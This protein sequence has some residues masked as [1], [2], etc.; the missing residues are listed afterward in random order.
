LIPFKLKKKKR[1]IN[2]RG[3]K[4]K[5]RGWLPVGKRGVRS[6]RKETG[7]EE[8]RVIVTRQYWRRRKKSEAASQSRLKRGEG[9]KKKSDFHSSSTLCVG[10]EQGKRATGRSKRGEEGCH[11][12][13]H[14]KGERKGTQGSTPGRKREKEKGG[15]RSLILSSFLK[16]KKEE[17]EAECGLEREKV[18]FLVRKGGGKGEDRKNS[19]ICWYDWEREK[20]GERFFFFIGAQGERR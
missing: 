8:R 11:I 3:G 13:P 5:T 12:L 20:R 2:K 19:V 14:F 16:G 4:I 15:G 1:R 6:N 18:Y 7:G 10:E 17:R 9:G